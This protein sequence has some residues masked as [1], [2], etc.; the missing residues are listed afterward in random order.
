MSSDPY[1]QMHAADYPAAE[2]VK[3][4][5]GGLENAIVFVS[6]GAP[7]GV[8][9]PSPAPLE[10]IQQNCHYV[11]HVFTMMTKQTLSVKNGDMTLHN[12]HVWAEKNPQFN[13]G[14][15]MKDL[16]NTTRFETP[17]VPIPIRCDVHRW[18]GAF[19]GVFDNPFNTVSRKGGA[20]ELKLPPGNYEITAWH[21]KFG[22]KTTTV[23]VS[24]NDRKEVDF[25]YGN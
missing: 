19:V 3:V 2:T 21:E 17:E 18:M 12:I 14:Q 23:M 7:Q 20:F 6:S 15:P 4:S 24:D 8:S 5:D 9:Y 13:V 22:K 16:T 25:S 11:P 1:C 10:I